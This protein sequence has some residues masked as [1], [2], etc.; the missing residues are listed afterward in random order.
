MNTSLMERFTKVKNRDEVNL[1]GMEKVFMK[2]M[3]FK[4]RDT[5]KE[6]INGTMVKYTKVTGKTTTCMV[7]EYSFGQMERN[8]RVITNLTKKVVSAYS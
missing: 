6:N 8:M 5:D 3:C 2:V 4:I 7:T 1:F